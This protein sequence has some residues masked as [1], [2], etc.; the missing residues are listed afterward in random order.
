MGRGVG[1]LGA[2]DDPVPAIDGDVALVA[3][4]RDRDVDLRLAVRGRLRLREL[5]RPAR[6]GVFLARL[7]RLFGPDVGGL[8]ACLDPAFSASVLRWRGAATSVASTIWPAIGRYGGTNDAKRRLGSVA[9]IR[10]AFVGI[11]GHLFR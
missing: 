7:R 9:A 5:H 2:A 10:D 4:G 1:D 8:L 3:E 11:Q 6:I